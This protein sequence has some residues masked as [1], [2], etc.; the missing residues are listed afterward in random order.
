MPLYQSFAPGEIFWVDKALE[1]AEEV[2]CNHYHISTCNWKKYGFEISNLA[3][4][5]WEEITPHSL[6]QITR[7]VHPFPK[8]LPL[9][10]PRD[11]YRVCLQ[12]HNILR[13]IEREEGI[14]LFPLMV[15]ILTHE[16]V[17]I[18]RFRKFM[19]RFDVEQDQKAIEEGKVHQTTYNILKTL[20][21]INLDPVFD[22]YSGHR[23]L[24][25]LYWQ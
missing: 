9:G 4:L 17:H 15:Y 16:L 3:Q 11:Y 5:R 21:G 8:G 13:V 7:Y 20:K 23:G 2:S 6:A 24:S 12:D 18:I 25:E 19:Q 1:I 22:S 10:Y 14:E